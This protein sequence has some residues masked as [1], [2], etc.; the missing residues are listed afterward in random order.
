[1]ILG[2][3]TL[4]Q[5]LKWLGALVLT[6][7]FV[8]MGLYLTHKVSSATEQNLV[9]RARGLVKTLAVQIVDPVL[10]DDRLTLHATLHKASTTDSEIRYLCIEN[11]QGEMVAHT[12]AGGYPTGL[13]KLWKEN[14]GL[15]ILYL[16]TDNEPLLD[17]STEILGGQLGTLHIGMSRA[18]VARTGGKLLLLMGI[19]LA[20]GMLVILIGVHLVAAKVSKPLHQLE[21]QVARFTESPDTNVQVLVSGIRELDSLSTCF[22]KMFESLQSLERERAATHQRMIHAERLAALGELAAGLAHEVHNPLDGMLGCL[23]Y[24]DDDPEKGERARKYHPMLKE[25][26]ERISRV[27]EQTLSFAHSGQETRLEVCE[28]GD[29]LRTVQTLVQA[30]MR[31]RAVQLN[32]DDTAS[33]SCLCDRQGLEQVVL[34]LILNAAEAAEENGM[35][36]VRI[37]VENNAEKVYLS[38]EDSGPGIPVELRDRIFEPFFTTKPIGKGTGLGL[39]VSRQLV[40]AAGGEIELCSQPSTL[41]GAKFVIRIPKA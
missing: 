24:L 28:I 38:V 9:E 37:E 3:W 8:P 7:V 30:Q 17:M 6:V 25:G 36:R 40:R 19:V 18:P 39:S 35:P 26:L 1:M 34:N 31:G 41:G 15:P 16:R 21:T 14:R 4:D 13:G 12:F 5:V 32:W 11:R 33:S 20:A 29:I 22:T 10:L 27:M 2:H 23:S